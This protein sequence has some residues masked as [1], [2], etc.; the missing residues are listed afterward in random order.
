MFRMIEVNTPGDV[1]LG[2]ILRIY[3][4]DDGSCIEPVQKLFD[5]R[6]GMTASAAPPTQTQSEFL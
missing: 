1:L 5:A 2:K 6:A 4:E 3:I